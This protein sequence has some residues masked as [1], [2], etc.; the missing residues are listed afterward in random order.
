MDTTRIV[1]ETTPRKKEALDAALQERGMSITEWF[2]E[3]ISQLARL[4]VDDDLED[5]PPLKCLSELANEPAVFSRIQ[6]HDWSYT[7]A[8]TTYLSHNLHPYPAKFIPQIPRSLIRML[9]LPGERIW[10]PFGGSGTTALE[11]LMLGRQ[12]VSSDLNPIAQTIGVAKTVTL[13]AEADAFLAEF[14]ERVEVLANAP[15]DFDAVADKYQNEIST[16]VPEIPNVEK[17]FAA[18]VIRELGYLRWKIDSF[19]NSEAKALAEAA[20]L[21]I[22]VK[23]SFQDSE[24]RYSSK[25]RA[26]EP[27]A[28]LRLF[29]SALGSSMA[30][31]RP[32]SSLLRF[33]A[34]EFVTADL[35]IDPVVDPASVDLIVS[36]PPY[37]NATDYHLYHRFR[38]FWHGQ[39]PRPLGRAEIGSH[40][41]HQKEKT[42]ID[43][44]MAEMEDCLR[45][46]QKGLRPG[47]YAVLVLGDAVF[48][49]REFKTAH[50]L[51]SV[52]KNAG[53]EC[54]GIVERDLHP[55][56]RSFV[57][58]ARRLRR[59]H[60]L[61]L[62]KPD[63]KLN[64]RL[65]APLYR[66]WDYE[67]TLRAREV[68]T[69]LGV[70][71]KVDTD[72]CY[73]T[74]GSLDSDKIKRLTFT[75]AFSAQ[76][77]ALE[78][79]WQAVL[80]N[81]NTLFSRPTRKNSKYVT[82]GVHAYKGKFY[83]QLA[84][85]LFNLASL[86]PG[87]SVLDPF[88]G[89]GTVVLEGYLN[90][91]N[92]IGLDL[93]PLAVAIANAKVSILT[94]DPALV[95]R[96][97]ARFIER[98]EVPVGH[99]GY[100][101][102]FAAESIEELEAWFPLPVLEKLAWVFLQIEDVPEPILRDFLAVCV[103]SIV[104]SISQ[105]EPRDLR[106]RRRKELLD[107]APVFDLLR[108]VIQNQRRHLTSFSNRTDR[109]PFPLGIAQVLEGDAR[110]RATL[111]QS[112][113]A[114]GSIDAV[115]TSPPYATALPYIDTDRLSILLLFGLRS[116]QRSQIEGS[117]VGSREIAKAAR[118]QIDSR[119]EAEEFDEIW[120]TSAVETVQH[121]YSLNDQADVGFRRKNKAALLYN[122]YRDMTTVMRNLEFATSHEANL[123][124]VIGD[125][126]TKAGGE[127]VTIKSGVALREIGK[128]IGWNLVDVIPISVTK[129]NRLHNRNS[130][131]E[132]E[133]IWFSKAGA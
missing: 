126:Q 73:V 116:R 13:T 114:C 109:A 32:L 48:Q 118:D 15:S 113:L 31:V 82:H 24:T 62:R 76:S 25:P 28:A 40:L 37:P 38:I 26:V 46:M 128:K 93:N 47:R 6:S 77:Y 59:E 81:G 17:W 33:R 36:S 130:I 99:G 22:V 67:E 86:A 11:A 133:I 49:G 19:P 87:E 2:E 9:S 58:A 103:S 83:P 78:R 107:D 70:P 79:T 16:S 90:G 131:T 132:N 42:G 60:L 85:S 102:V 121:V 30:K 55:T 7:D 95:D 108:D 75:H 120:S 65:H 124:F 101:E 10:D 1:V 104:R 119:I 51:E 69:V 61:V 89:S 12:A 111:D 96:R 68:A 44:Y 14:V 34:A 97:L 35:R 98:L 27:G 112:R 122:Y 4:G 43:Q 52:A 66:L 3:N 91:L 106:I 74:A 115:V 50:M 92:S 105:Q 54:V 63:E 94:L 117:L 110:D 71:C 29:A 8:D 123:F 80:E 5:V 125:N 23:A 72:G 127:N 20:F 57:S 18:Q 100:E 56:K 39:D 21:S 53:F 88:C 64:F 41:R 129:E 45:H 84:K